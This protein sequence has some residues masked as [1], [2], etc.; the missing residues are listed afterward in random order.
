MKSSAEGRSTWVNLSKGVAHLL[1]QSLL[2][3]SLTDL[4]HSAQAEFQPERQNSKVRKLLTPHYFTDRDYPWMTRSYEEFLSFG[5]K[6]RREAM[7]YFQSVPSYYAPKKK[8]ALLFHI[9]L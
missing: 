9:L 1:P 7:T 8:R 6:T 2:I 3:Y 5:G 4:N